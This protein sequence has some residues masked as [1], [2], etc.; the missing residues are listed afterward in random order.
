MVNN[1]FKRRNNN[2]NNDH[3]AADFDVDS[4]DDTIPPPPP[5]PLPMSKT[6]SS[7]DIINIENNEQTAPGAAA[8]SPT[9]VM[10][11]DHVSIV[12]SVKT[13]NEEF[14]DHK[15]HST[16][17]SS[18]F[19]TPSKDDPNG[20]STGRGL[21]P[22]GYSQVP[23]TGQFRGMKNAQTFDEEEA[24]MDEIEVPSSSVVDR[25][26]EW[27]VKYALRK[28][29]KYIALIV[30]AVVLVIVGVSLAGVYGA[31]AAGGSQNRGDN[32]A[33]GDTTVEGSDGGEDDYVPV[34]EGATEGS[35]YP[36]HMDTG[37]GQLLWDHEFLPTSTMT[38]L[39]E[40]DADS[41]AYKAW[42]WLVTSDENAGYDFESDVEDMNEKTKLDLVQRFSL[43]AMFNSM[44]EEEQIDGWMTADDV[45]DWTGVVCG[46]EEEEVDGEV[47]E[48][49]DGDDV[50]R[51]RQLKKRSFASRRR[52]QD[53]NDDQLAEHRIRT[54][55]V[56]NQG[57][58]GTIPAE[59]ALLQDLYNIE[60]FGNKLTGEIPEDLYTITSLEILDLFN[61]ELTGNISPEIGN[62]KNLVALY[63]GK[64]QFSGVIPTNLYTL[65]SL[66]ALWMDDL[67]ELTG[68]QLSPDIAS[69]TNL[70]Q[71]RISRSAF[72]GALP[73]EIGSMVSLRELVAFQCGFDGE[74]PNLSDLVNLEVLDLSNNWFTGPLPKLRQL[75]EL[76]YLRLNGNLLSGR[77]WN[78]YGAL[79]SLGKTLFRSG[80]IFFIYC[81][82]VVLIDHSLLFSLVELRLGPNTLDGF[83][84]A[85]LV[86]DVPD[87]L[88]SLANLSE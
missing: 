26:N 3:T 27:E 42:K 72:V 33:A 40:Q 31:K 4:D 78:H 60:L 9:G 81:F 12:S 11:M 47:E 2:G 83:P 85:G 76:K 10:Q 6:S 77:I 62:L 22:R 69:L 25:W 18:P 43:A 35:I 7:M 24:G 55:R 8:T 84:D 75:G 21:G 51:R 13:S 58:T 30:V 14:Y 66:L 50:V 32:D 70:E 45:C 56:T 64:N 38:A 63:L 52:L 71:L 73:D 82:F 53:A 15:S 29:C 87:S 37:A 67:N 23:I 61:N 44:G 1:P 48:E 59:L 88:G 5:P 16:M 68:Q 74:I 54:I 49:V 19:V 65:D 20:S 28:K 46:D 36:D 41:A 57:I 79:F 17:E 80:S 39:E 34:T 86:E